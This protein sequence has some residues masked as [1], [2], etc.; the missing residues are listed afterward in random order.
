MEFCE[1][2]RSVLVSAISPSCWQSKRPFCFLLHN[3]RLYLLFLQGILIQG[4]FEHMCMLSHQVEYLGIYVGALHQ[5]EK[6]L[7]ISSKP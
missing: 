3:T 6:V 2:D 4:L 5:H 1:A 7:Q